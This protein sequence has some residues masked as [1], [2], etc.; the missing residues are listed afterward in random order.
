MKVLIVGNKGMLGQD[1][2]SELSAGNIDYVGLDKDEIDITK[3]SE[4]TK[5]DSSF[6]HV[7]NCAAYTNVDGAES[8]HDLCDAI[9]VDGVKNLVD[10]CKELDIVF[11]SISTDYVFD[12]EQES[13]DE[14]ASRDPLN[15]YGLS[16]AKGEEYIESN[17][18]KY[19]IVRTA[20][21]FGKKGNNFVETM[22]KL[23]KSKNE[24]RVVD[25]QKGSPTY[26]RDLSKGL[27]G[28][29]NSKEYGIYHFTNSGS[30][31]WFEFA[32]EIMKLAGL[33]CKVLPCTSEEFLRD[34]KRPKFS[35]L[36]NN[37]KVQL[38]DWKDALKRYLDE[39]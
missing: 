24:I 39:V 34:A 35:I 7:I 2:C 32:T 22:I 27:I 18:D 37:K 20:W 21:L 16:K 23:G 29:L 12:G 8:N 38:P 14:D 3:V 36:N 15:Y 19:F 25:D 1:L 17:L 10:R 13:Y 26:T 30:C 6:T 31:T 9:N 11:I 5:I 4:M 28:L 33:D